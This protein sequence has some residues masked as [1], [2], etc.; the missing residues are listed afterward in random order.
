MQTIAP[1]H[2]PTEVYTYL[3]QKVQIDL[4]GLA[5][6]GAG[7][8]RQQRR[9]LEHYVHFAQEPKSVADTYNETHH[10]LLRLCNVS[11]PD[12]VTPVWKRLVNCHKS[13]QF[14]LLTQELQEVCSARGMST[15]LYVP[16]VTTT[17]KQMVVGFQF[18]GNGPDNLATGCQPFLTSYAG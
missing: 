16:V 1:V 15:Q 10:V 8:V 2:L 4:P 5:T 6:A 7:G 12:E 17:V 14:T 18:A 9:W 3:T 13:E 11:R